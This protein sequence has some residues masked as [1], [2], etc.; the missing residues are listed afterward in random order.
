MCGRLLALFLLQ[1]CLIHD[2]VGELESTVLSTPITV[3]CSTDTNTDTD[4]LLIV[5]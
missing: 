4:R 3:H 2:V 5:C 1:T